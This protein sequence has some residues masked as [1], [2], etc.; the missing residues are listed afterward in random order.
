M[1]MLRFVPHQQP[2]HTYLTS[3]DYAKL[4]LQAQNQLKTMPQSGASWNYD[5]LQQA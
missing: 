1:V 3:A 5:L 2:T 4:A